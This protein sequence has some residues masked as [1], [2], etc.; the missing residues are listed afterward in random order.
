VWVRNAW[1]ERGIGTALILFAVGLMRKRGIRAASLSVLHNNIRAI[2]LYCRLN[3]TVLKE[4]TGAK[5]RL[6]YIRMTKAL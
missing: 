6:T 5:T 4:F 1:Q 2:A 3:W